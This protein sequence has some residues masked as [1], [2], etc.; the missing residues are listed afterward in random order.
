MPRCQLDTS[1]RR[2]SK[3]EIF[4]DSWKAFE[5]AFKAH[6][7][8]TY[9]LYVIRSTTSKDWT[10]RMEIRVSMAGEPAIVGHGTEKTWISERFFNGTQSRFNVRTDGKTIVLAAPGNEDVPWSFGRR[11]APPTCVCVCDVA[12]SRT[13]TR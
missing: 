10:V 8:A 11:T 1:S 12:V 9:E 7:R 5:D 4:P 6:G 13:W 3:F 2:S